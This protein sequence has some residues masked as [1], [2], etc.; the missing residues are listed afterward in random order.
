VLS[1]YCPN[2]AMLGVYV[3]GFAQE[4]ILSCFVGKYYVGDSCA[5]LG[6]IYLFSGFHRWMCSSSDDPLHNH[7]S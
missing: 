4:C 1:L 2:D 7:F 3:S 6:S 5:K